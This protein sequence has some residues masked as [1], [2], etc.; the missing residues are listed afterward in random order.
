MGKGNGSA[1]ETPWE[2][3]S[4]W[5]CT[6]PSPRVLWGWSDPTDPAAPGMKQADIHSILIPNLTLQPPSGK[7]NTPG[8]AAAPPCPAKGLQLPAQFGGRSGQTLMASSQ[9]TAP[10]RLSLLEGFNPDQS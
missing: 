10:G 4:S 6:E 3:H 7:D 2:G 5:P 9:N 8:N 1:A